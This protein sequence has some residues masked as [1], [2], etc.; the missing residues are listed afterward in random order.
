MGTIIIWA[1]IIIVALQL[2][3][4]APVSFL[5]AWVL[6]ATAAKLFFEEVSR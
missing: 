3:F 1:V 4:P 6:V 5:L 2:P